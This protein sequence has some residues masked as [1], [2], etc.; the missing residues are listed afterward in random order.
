MDQ[1]NPVKPFILPSSASQ[2]VLLM[3][4]GFPKLVS[5]T[6]GM[7]QFSAGILHSCCCCYPPI[8]PM[9]RLPVYIFVPQGVF[10]L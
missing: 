2:A 8:R 6:R 9:I 4:A 10:L 7:W 5:Q 1:Q 3:D